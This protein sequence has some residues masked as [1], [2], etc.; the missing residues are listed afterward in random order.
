MKR[1]GYVLHPYE[2]SHA[3]GMGYS[4]LEVCKQIASN[5]HSFELTIYTS[6]PVDRDK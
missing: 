3:S 4:M 6:A 1:V 5:P 2:E